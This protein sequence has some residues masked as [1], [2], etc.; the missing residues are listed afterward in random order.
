MRNQ[1]NNLL[2]KQ[3]KIPIWILVG[4][5]ILS[6]AMLWCKFF[7]HKNNRIN[8]FCLI[9]MIVSLCC[10]TPRHHN[11]SIQAQELI[12]DNTYEKEKLQPSKIN[13]ANN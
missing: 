5:L 11:L 10:H 4:V 13:F 7:H 9:D 3:P 8:P 6:S 2:H 12:I 1:W